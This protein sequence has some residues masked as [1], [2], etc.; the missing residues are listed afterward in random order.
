MPKDEKTYAVYILTDANNG[1]LYTGVT[2]DLGK[3]VW[4]HKNHIVDGFTSRYHVTKLVYFETCEN[5]YGAITREK[6]IKAG[7][8]WKKIALIDNLNPG[9]RDLSEGL[10][11]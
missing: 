7:S 2:G 3:R 8:R 6:Q 10:F 9:W 4:E 11:A 1:V 5:A